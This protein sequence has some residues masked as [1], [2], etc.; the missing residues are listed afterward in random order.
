MEQAEVQPPSTVVDTPAKKKKKRTWL[1]ILLSVLGVLAILIG[2]FVWWVLGGSQGNPT[3]NAQLFLDATKA[4][5][6]EQAY[7]QTAQVFK[8]STSQD[9]FEAFLEAYPILAE[10][11]EIKFSGVERQSGEG[12]TISVL[13]GTITSTAGVEQPIEVTMISENGEWKVATVDLQPAE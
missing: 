2:L 11:S 12:K 13:S 7:T 6:T 5:Q 8:N 10:F 1:W 9:D 3:K 4:G